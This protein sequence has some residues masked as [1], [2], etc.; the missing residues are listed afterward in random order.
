MKS[1]WT[2]DYLWKK[3]KDG[4]GIHKWIAEKKAELQETTGVPWTC[5]TGAGKYNFL[6]YLDFK[7]IDSI[8]DRTTVQ[9]FLDG[10][11]N[12]KDVFKM[13]NLLQ[14]HEA[15]GLDLPTLTGVAIHLVRIQAISIDVCRSGKAVFIKSR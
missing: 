7:S 8:D 2:D 3:C 14:I 11:D 4:R 12:V 9:T 10:F 15:T 5:W 6:P 1:S 13:A